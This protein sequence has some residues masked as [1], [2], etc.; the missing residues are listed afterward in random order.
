VHLVGY[1]DG[2]NIMGRKK[3]AVYEVYEEL[4]ESS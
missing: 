3:R 4:K 2:I 1:A